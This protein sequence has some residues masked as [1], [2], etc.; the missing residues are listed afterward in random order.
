MKK[1]WHFIEICL[2]IDRQKL[3]RS[4]SMYSCRR[5][6]CLCSPLKCFIVSGLMFRSLIHFEFIFV[7]GVRKWSSFLMS[8]LTY[9]NM[10]HMEASLLTR[11]LSF[12]L[13]FKISPRQW[14]VQLLGC[15]QNSVHKKSEPHTTF[16]NRFMMWSFLWRIINMLLLLLLTC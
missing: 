5:V 8:S 1:N 14:V 9:A 12:L 7:Y 4:K 10:R 3:I 16:R 2:H 13:W 11:E 6:F 15:C